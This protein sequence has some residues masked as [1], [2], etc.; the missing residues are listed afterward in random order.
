MLWRRRLRLPRRHSCR[1][2]A[3]FI[4]TERLIE[5]IPMI[6]LL[7]HWTAIPTRQDR[8]EWLDLHRGSLADVRQ[9]LSDISRI[10]RWLG[11][12]AALR[13]FLFPRMRQAATKRRLRI[14]DVGTGSAAVPLEIVRWARRHEIR[15]EIVAL[16]NNPR[17]L[18]VAREEVSAYE[19]IQLLAADVTAI[20]FPPASFDFVLSMLFLHHFSRGELVELLPALKA[21][22]RG[23]LLLNDLVRDRVPY[24]FFRMSAP[25]FARSRLTRHDGEVSI[26]RA[27]TPSEMRSILAGADLGSARV[28][29]Q[30]LHYRMTVIHDNSER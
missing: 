16:D 30:G 19:E 21:I 9:S 23:T 4:A 12:R 20:P 27:Y 1:R 6:P 17:H 22:C 24:L 14:L 2:L 11:G 29:T 8:P 5:I 28:Y 18:S 13:R 3:Q 15:V 25:V 26:F 10:N 7:D